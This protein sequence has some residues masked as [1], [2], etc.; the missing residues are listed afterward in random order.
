MLPLSAYAAGG[1]SIS[2][3]GAPGDRHCHPK[4][5]PLFKHTIEAIKKDAEDLPFSK[6][7]SV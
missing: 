3:G 4:G 1:S 2:A 6:I 5:K 7:S